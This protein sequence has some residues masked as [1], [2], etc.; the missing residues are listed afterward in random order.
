MIVREYGPADHDACAALFQE[1]L[2]THRRLYP[3]TRIEGVF[4][5]DGRLFVAE[6]DGSIVGY[7]GLVWHGRRA[8][9]EP[10]VVARGMCG[11]GA[12]RALAQRVVEEARA[13]GGLRI[14]VTP[15]AR[16]RD[17]IV[18]FH[19]FGFDVIGSVQLQIDLEPRRRRPGAELAGRRFK[20]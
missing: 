8:E 6:D 13:R 5:P 1:L 17:A 19:E 14:F 3:D 9:I 10:I 4:D 11:R 18:F 2:D 12:G 7:A 16:N 15:A 20:V